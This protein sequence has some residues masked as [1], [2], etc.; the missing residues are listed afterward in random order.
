MTSLPQMPGANVLPTNNLLANKNTS[1]KRLP[2]PH[3]NCFTVDLF[4]R[5]PTHIA[6]SPIHQWHRAYSRYIAKQ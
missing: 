1:T 4:L 5:R 3:I 6:E 2:D